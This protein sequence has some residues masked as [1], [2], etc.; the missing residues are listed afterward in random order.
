MRIEDD[1][2]ELNQKSQD[3]NPQELPNRKPGYCKTNRSEAKRFLSLTDV[4]YDKVMRIKALV[5]SG[6]YETEE[7][8]RRTAEQLADFLAEK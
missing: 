5:E 3:Y 1:S 7:K 4:R 6:R 8:I 2:P